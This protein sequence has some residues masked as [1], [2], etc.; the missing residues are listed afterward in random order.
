MAELLT[1]SARKNFC[2]PLH[3]SLHKIDEQ[4]DGTGALVCSSSYKTFSWF[5]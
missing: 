3:F 5:F 4:R 2:N 1:P